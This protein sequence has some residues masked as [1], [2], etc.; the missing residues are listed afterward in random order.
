M[1]PHIHLAAPLGPAGAEAAEPGGTTSMEECWANQESRVRLRTPVQAFFEG[2][3]SALYLSSKADC[4]QP[5]QL[6]WKG[7]ML[8]FPSASVHFNQVS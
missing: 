8:H 6:L 7:L 3:F 1:G 4:A 5:G 2:F